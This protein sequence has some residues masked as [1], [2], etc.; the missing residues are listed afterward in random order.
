MSDRFLK[1]MEALS[2]K[3]DAELEEIGSST[4]STSDGLNADKL[5]GLDSTQFLRS[6]IDQ[7]MNGN[8]DFA[9]GKELRLKDNRGVLH[10]FGKDEYNSTLSGITLRTESNPNAGDPI[11]T[12]RSEGE[13]P[14]LIVEH[15]GAVK[16]YNDDYYVSVDVNGDG[17]YKVWH[18]NNDGSG[19]GLDADLVDGIQASQLVRNDIDQTMDASYHIT[20]DLTVDGELKAG[21]V[22]ETSSIKYKENVKS[23]KN[24]LNL[25]NGLQGVT[26]TWKDTGKHDYGFIA[27]EVDKVLPELVHRDKNNEIDGMNYSKITSILV[28]AIKE[29]QTQIEE[30]KNR[31][32]ELERK[33]K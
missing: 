29:Q 20:G 10:S 2:E 24:P 14:R 8:L 7:T 32:E 31:V 16:T 12:V 22:T 11:F 30:L 33:I 3:L 13:A 9:S 1:K 19:S 28:E 23:I 6:D 25:V 27:E 17:G 18:Q 21:T 26:Y 5:D 15:E 4:S